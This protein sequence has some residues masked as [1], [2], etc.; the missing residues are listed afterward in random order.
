MTDE[1]S[2][3]QSVLRKVEA[4]ERHNRRQKRVGIVALTTVA[5]LLLM[6][7]AGPRTNPA[8]GRTL[9][10]QKLLLRDPHGKL[11]CSL[12][13]SEHGATLTMYGSND[14]ARMELFNSAD[15]SALRLFSGN[16]KLR[17][18]LGESGNTTGIELYNS[19]GKEQADFS[20]AVDGPHLKLGDPVGKLLASLYTDKNR[21]ALTLYDQNERDR[22]S[23]FIGGNGPALLFTDTNEKP[24]LGLEVRRNLP[25]LQIADADGRLIWSPPTSAAPESQAV[26]K[27]RPH[28]LIEAANMPYWPESAPRIPEEELNPM[29]TMLSGMGRAERTSATDEMATFARRCPDAAVTVEQAKG[30]YTIRLERY[31]GGILKANNQELVL[32]RYFAFDAEGT[33]IGVGSLAP[34]LG[35]AIDQACGKIMTHWAS[36]HPTR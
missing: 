25:I 1:T 30:D 21:P 31:Y 17:A 28:V 15:G 6:G 24:L 36:A 11:K 20:L 7:Q 4:L 23:L 26:T 35:E 27:A 22:V 8:P 5:A 29:R 13:A 33:Q 19:D 14:E 12:T 32:F 9:E 16:G 34:S 18:G 2:D 3:L 10:A